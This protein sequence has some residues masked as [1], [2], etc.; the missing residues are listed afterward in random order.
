MKNKLRLLYAD[1]VTTEKMGTRKPE[2]YP[3]DDDYIKLALKE[4][5]F[6]RIAVCFKSDVDTLV[7][8]QKKEYDKLL[9]DIRHCITPIYK[10]LFDERVK[11]S[12]NFLFENE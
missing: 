3:Y 6:E 10:K 9:S 11:L 2:N 8:E 12:K 1:E 5:T 7:E 4:P